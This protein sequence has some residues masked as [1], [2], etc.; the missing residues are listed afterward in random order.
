MD[1][2]STEQDDLRIWGTDIKTDDHTSN[3]KYDTIEE[4]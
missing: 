3:D 4:D 2:P 1:C